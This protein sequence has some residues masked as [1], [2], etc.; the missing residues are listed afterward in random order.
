MAFDDGEVESLYSISGDAFSD[1]TQLDGSPEEHLPVK[2]SVAAV[3]SCFARASR[4]PD[5]TICE[6]GKCSQL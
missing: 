2:N 3:H 1:L 4:K 5:L 6:H